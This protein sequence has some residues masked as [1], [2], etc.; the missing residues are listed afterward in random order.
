M[1][2]RLRA[3]EFPE[4]V[5]RHLSNSDAAQHNGNRIVSFDRMHIRQVGET[6][7]VSPN[8]F[9]YVGFSGCNVKGWSGEE[10]SPGNTGRKRKKLLVLSRNVGKECHLDP[11]FFGLP[12]YCRNSSWVTGDVENGWLQ[13]PQLGKQRA[14]IRRLLKIRVRED[15][16]SAEFVESCDKDVLQTN[17]VVIVD[18]NDRRG[19]QAE[20]PIAILRCNHS[21]ERI[22]WPDSQEVLSCLRQLRVGGRWGNQKHFAL[23]SDR[24]HR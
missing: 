17:A 13:L 20:L 11:E 6:R 3:C 23:L 7:L 15:H 14:K 19:T 16:S 8:E 4:V 24:V 21:V 10:E 1:K 12:K 5:R 22:G 9:H 18:A 2:G